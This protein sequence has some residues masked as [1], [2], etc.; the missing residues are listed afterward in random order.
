MR[1]HFSLGGLPTPHKHPPSGSWRSQEAPGSGLSTPESQSWPASHPTEPR[2]PILQIPTSQG[3]HR[4]SK[5]KGREVKAP[6]WQVTVVGH[7][8]PSSRREGLRVT[9]HVASL[10]CRLR[11]LG[12]GKPAFEKPWPCVWG[13][14]PPTLIYFYL[15][16][17]GQHN[18][19]L[20][21]SEVVFNNSSVVCNTW[22]SSQHIG[23]P[24]MTRMNVSGIS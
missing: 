8:S 19:I 20:L 24:F 11:E 4:I 22:C 21:V 23:A 9:I 12:E 17:V 13:L 15:T 2:F 10:G 14:F 16:S 5:G 6:S 7:R 1:G 3:G 18:S